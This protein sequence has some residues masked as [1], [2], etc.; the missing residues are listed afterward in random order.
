MTWAVTG[1]DG[2]LG[3]ALRNL[4]P[5]ESPCDFQPLTHRDLDITKLPD[6]ERL[7]GEMRPE[8]VINTAA[9]NF[10]DKAEEQP[11][12][13]MKLNAGGPVVL[14][15]V[16]RSLKIPLLH[17]STDFVFGGDKQVPYDEQDLP[18]PLSAY[19]RSKLKGEQGVRAGN[20]RHFIVRTCGVYGRAYSVGKGNF[21]ETILRLADERE[22]LSVVNDQR[23]TPTSARE[24]ALGICR[25]IQTEDWGTYHLTCQGNCSWY[26]FAA[27]ILKQAGKKTPVVPIGSSDYPAKAIRPH[28][29]VLNCDKLERT[30]GFRAAAWEQALQFYLA[31]RES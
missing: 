14:A 18:N 28:Y 23:C 24:L 10:V 7:F 5:G 16:C 9:Y 20:P 31:G 6:V 2:Q 17:V 25:L 4:S 29:S 30:T 19:A 21:V 27:E 8:G 26:E 3:T 15:A 1:A 12:E 13:A 22:Q 11:L